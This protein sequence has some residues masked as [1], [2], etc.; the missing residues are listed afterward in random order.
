MKAVFLALMRTT[1]VAMGRFR[2]TSCTKFNKAGVV[3]KER[4]I[5]K[6]GRKQKIEK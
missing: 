2:L 4:K 6:K 3:A 5:C 1:D